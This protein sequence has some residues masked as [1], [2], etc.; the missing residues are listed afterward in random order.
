MGKL[1]LKSGK[2]K[3]AVPEVGQESDTLNKLKHTLGFPESTEFLGYAIYREASGEFLAALKGQEEEGTTK[4]S[5]TKTVKSADLHRTLASAVEIS[6]QYPAA[7]VVGLFNTG[8]QIM[9]VTM[10]VK[11]SLSEPPTY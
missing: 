2:K 8:E 1:K 5:W 4:S 6:T 7:A 11:Q 10:S 3:K 9:T